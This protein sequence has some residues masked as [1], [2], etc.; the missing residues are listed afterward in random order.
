MNSYQIKLGSLNFDPDKDKYII[1]FLENLKESRKLQEFLKVAVEMIVEEPEMV[2]NKVEF[3]NFIR[4]FMQFSGSLPKDKFIQESK[5]EIREMQRKIDSIYEKTI[6]LYMLAQCGKRNG[7]E[8][9]SKNTMSAQFIAQQQVN[10]L[11]KLLGTDIT[12]EYASSKV[13][14]QTEWADKTVAFILDSYDGLMRESVNN[15]KI[16]KLAIEKE[17]TSSSINSEASKQQQIQETPKFE[18]KQITLSNEDDLIDLDIKP[19]EVGEIDAS[20]LDNVAKFFGM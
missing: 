1:Q 2:S 11:N 19:G 14:E 6:E 13:K 5:R 12:T 9:K 20:N 17:E 10:S 8:D 3:E 7:L 18:P 15:A 4:A 16:A